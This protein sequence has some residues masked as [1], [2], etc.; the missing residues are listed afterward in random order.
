MEIIS[1]IFYFLADLHEN[2]GWDPAVGAAFREI[3]DLLAA[4]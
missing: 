1:K 2:T 3:G 4:I